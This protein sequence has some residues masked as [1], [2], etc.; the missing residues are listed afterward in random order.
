MAR[1]LRVNAPLPIGSRPLSGVTTSKCRRDG[2]AAVPPGDAVDLMARGVTGAARRA[3]SSS[4]A[5]LTPP[6]PPAAVAVRWGGAAAGAQVVRFPAGAGSV[7]T[8]PSGSGASAPKPRRR[9]CSI[10]L[11]PPPIQFIVRGVQQR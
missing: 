5:T 7:Q 3:A 11:R 6:A 9:R 2:G 10:P 8:G 1:P 4:P